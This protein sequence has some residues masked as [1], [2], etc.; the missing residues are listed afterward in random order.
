MSLP[1]AIVLLVIV[2]I[3]AAFLL[4]E[5]EKRYEIEPPLILY[6]LIIPGLLVLIALIIVLGLIV[7]ILRG[8]GLGIQALIHV[9]FHKTNDKKG[10]DHNGKSGHRGPPPEENDEGD[11]G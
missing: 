6:I 3:I 10:D 11:G 1:M 9:I 7:G 8:I 5:I 4:P 2:D